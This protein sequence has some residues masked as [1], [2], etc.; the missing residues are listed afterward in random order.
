MAAS[1][2]GLKPAFLNLS[3]LV[4]APNAVI[5][6][7]K[8]KVSKVTIAFT[9]G[10]GSR[11]KL[12]KQIT[13]KNIIANQGTCIFFFSPSMCSPLA[14]FRAAKKA[15]TISTGTNIITRIIFTM[16]ALSLIAAPIALPAPTTWA[17]S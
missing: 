6:I 16:I 17:T 4:S 11:L 2:K 3:I 13:N 9:T 14:A 1:K 15:I 5:A 8:R 7:V 12:L 10:A